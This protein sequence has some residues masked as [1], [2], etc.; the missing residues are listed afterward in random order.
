MSS[1]IERFIRDAAEA[2]GITPDVAVIV[3]RSEGGVDEYARRGTFATGSSWWP[4]QLHYGGP[5]YEQYGT[6]AGMGAGFTELT[7]WQPGDPR[8]WRDSVRYALNRAKAGGWS[9]V[10]R[11]RRCR[12]QP[13]VRHRPLGVVGRQRRDMGLRTTRGARRARRQDRHC[14]RG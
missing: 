5:G 14:I 11:R 1:E 2:R 8:A 10:V 12:G 4:F 6:V 3:A 13:L 9:R 7:G